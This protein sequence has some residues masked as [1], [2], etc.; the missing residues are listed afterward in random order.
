MCSHRR[1][2]DRSEKGLDFIRRGV[3][4]FSPWKHAISMDEI[5]QTGKVSGAPKAQ[6]HTIICPAWG[7][8]IIGTTIIKIANCDRLLRRKSISAAIPTA[9]EMG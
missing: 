1:N 9:A 5:S 2:I 7:A 4:L 3:L 6:I 8:L